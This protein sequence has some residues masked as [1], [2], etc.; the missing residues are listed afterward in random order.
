MHKSKIID[1]LSNL[2]RKMKQA[3]AISLD[4]AA[5][6]LAVWLAFSLRLDLWHMPRHPQLWLY[7]AGGVTFLFPFI[8][9]GLYRAIFRYTGIAALK[10]ILLALL[11]HAALFVIAFLFLYEPGYFPRSLVITQPIIFGILVITSRFA[12]R[13]IFSD[14]TVPRHERRRVVI[15]GAG[16][17][18]I[19]TAHS[20]AQS[21]EYL[22][23]GFIDTDPAKQTRMLDG[24]R[25]WAPEYIDR[26][27]ANN[28][29]DEVM[30][31]I[32][33]S[34]STRLSIIRQLELKGVKVTWLPAIDDISA[35]KVKLSDALDIDPD[36][37]L[38]RAK[39]PP[40][41]AM[42]RAIVANKTVLV[43]GG[44]G[45]IGSEIC[46]QALDFGAARL[47]IVDHNEY[48][49]YEIEHICALRA[50]DLQPCPTIIPV[51]GSVRF[52]SRIDEIIGHYKP[53]V[54]FHAAAYKHV[55]LVELH[56]EE[57]LQTNTFGTFNVASAAIRHKVKRFVLIS[58]D[59]AVRPTNIMGA[60]KRLAEMIVQSLGQAKEIS[61]S[62]D[63]SSPEMATFVSHTLFSAVRFGNVL[64]S[65]GSVIPRF[66][67][68]IRDGGPI[69]LTHP[70]ITRYFMTIPEAS[71][72]VMQAG[73]MAK[74]GEVFVLDMGQ[75]VKIYD[76]AARM[77]TL[78]GLSLRDKDNPLGD[79]EIIV[80]KMRPGE[81]LHEE[82]VISKKM[83]KTA[84]KRITQALDEAPQFIDLQDDLTQLK[85]AGV[86]L[87]KKSKILVKLTDYRPDVI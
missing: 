63:G 13:F 28:A 77:I 69:Q 86:S 31:A 34:R 35:G 64:D 19:Q 48:G 41:S 75:P 65:S 12:I 85:S 23:L 84:H 58:T 53:D 29:I 82:L 79:I 67:Q 6:L 7:A 49:L 60:T 3:M 80:T 36:L 27:I 55:P 66:R 20:L 38:G 2:P 46:R 39:V 33:H 57:G 51:L 4:M 71:Q 73:A 87:Y 11:V 30:L 25:V 26:L 18:G 76:L 72:L 24:K 74:N 21:P 83:S 47:I 43:T 10:T 40:D 68:Q 8:R 45:S 42:M 9:L 52:A 17:T 44:A 15:Y 70:D 54:I 62:K 5:G 56:P 78:S 1:F 14:D 61:L 16:R 32:R 50:A 59:K 22:V 37:L 81:K